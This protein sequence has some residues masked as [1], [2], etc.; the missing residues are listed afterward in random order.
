MSKIDQPFLS[1]NS[2][3]ASL[4]QTDRDYV[5]R[6]CEPSELK[7]GATIC[8]P[9][10]VIKHVYFPADSYISLITPAGASES[11][12]VGMVGDEGMFGVTLLLDVKAS[13][14]QGL[15]QGAGSALRMTASRFKVAVSESV[16]FRRTLNRYLYVL[17]SQ[18]AQTAACN[19]YHLLDARLA[20]W[21]LMTQDRA[22]SDTYRLTHEF[23][24]YMLGVRRT[25][26]TEAAGQLQAKGLIRYSRG[27]LTVLNRT[28][29]EAL[30]CSC[31]AAFTKMYQLHL[32]QP[33]TI[34]ARKPGHKVFA[35]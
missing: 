16:P 5:G 20:R 11:I 35:K 26:V 21:L 10:N 8:K 28:G 29:L 34:A 22:H 33:R 32:Q 14:L 17:T 6:F 24:A 25:G 31:Y 15:V 4:P 27:E 9:G 7:F 23:L 2:L 18:L 19:R 13:P 1:A 12:E 3:L 30:A